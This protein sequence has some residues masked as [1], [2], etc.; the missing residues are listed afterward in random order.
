MKAINRK[1]TV[2]F[3]SSE[4]LVTWTLLLR[5][6][7]SGS[8]CC[9]GVSRRSTRR[10]A[11][12]VP[13]AMALAPLR[14]HRMLCLPAPGATWRVSARNTGGRS[15]NELCPPTACRGCRRCTVTHTH[16]LL[17]RPGRTGMWWPKCGFS[18]QDKSRFEF[19]YG[20]FVVLH[21]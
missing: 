10:P 11:V 7:F 20:A 16:C 4:I 12:V 1:L 5:W 3:S 13:A 15:L 6:M 19:E 8:R 18:K 9:A 14:L 2:D 17:Y 21:F